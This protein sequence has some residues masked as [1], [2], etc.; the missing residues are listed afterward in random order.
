MKRGV[1]HAIIL[2]L[3]SGPSLT[4]GHEWTIDTEFVLN[5]LDFYVGKKRITQ[6]RISP[7]ES[8]LKPVVRPQM[9]DPCFRP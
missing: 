5:R 7:L 3:L 9:E 4:W 2:L 6:I 8:M 1:T